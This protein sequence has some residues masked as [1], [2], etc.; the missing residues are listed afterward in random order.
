MSQ[1][2]LVSLQLSQFRVRYKTRGKWRTAKKGAA[3][4]VVPKSASS[5]SI[6]YK[7]LSRWLKVRTIT[8]TAKGPRYIGVGKI[9]KALTSPDKSARRYQTVFENITQK[10]E[11]AEWMV[12]P[13]ALRAL[14][15]WAKSDVFFNEEA[16]RNKTFTQLAVWYAIEAEGISGAA[17]PKDE[18]EYRK[19][20]YVDATYFEIE[21]QK[22][23]DRL[24][25]GFNDL[26]GPR[27]IGPDGE[28]EAHN[29]G[30][31]QYKWRMSYTLLGV[32]GVNYEV[33]RTGR[34]RRHAKGAGARNK[35][36]GAKPDRGVR[37]RNRAGA[38][39]PR[40]GGR[41]KRGGK[42]S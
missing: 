36:Q 39:V 19:A 33:S 28:V 32:E 22:L 3:S 38:S 24:L 2:R 26:I 1:A 34:V 25:L 16:D 23:S 10:L 8:G 7:P 41:H 12:R 4:F 5:Y 35:V 17:A 20:Y 15:Q 21:A 42:R 40:S 11:G 31:H 27:V 18:T 6:E 29:S 37:H 9:R 14:P 13:R 30:P